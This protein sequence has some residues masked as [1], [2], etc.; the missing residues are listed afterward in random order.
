MQENMYFEG[1]GR[2]LMHGPHTVSGSSANLRMLS[3]SR[4]NR[5]LSPGGKWD[6][7]TVLL[8]GLRKKVSRS[9]TSSDQV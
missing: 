6:I 1:G 8:N 4:A 9:K 3:I 5:W 7:P 2:G